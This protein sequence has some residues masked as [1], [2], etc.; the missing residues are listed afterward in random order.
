MPDE[1]AMRTISCLL[2]GVAAFTAVQSANAQTDQERAAA[3]D[4]ANA[5]HT[6]FAA[7][8]YEKAIDSLTRAEQLVH[9]PTHL[10]FLARAQTKLG[11]LVAAHETYLKITRET[12][13]SNAP[14]AFVAAQTSAEQEQDALEAR[15]PSV[16]VTLRGP[17]SGELNVQMD[18][19]KL[20]TAMIGIP[21][22]ADPGEHVF[23]A[24]SATSVSEAVTIKLSEA[25]KQSVALELRGTGAVRAQPKAAPVAA[26]AG[27]VAAS[28]G[29]VAASAATPPAEAAGT[30]G[31]VTTAPAAPAS[32]D[33]SS[34]GG[35]G[36][37]VASVISFGIG[38]V[39]LG[40]GTYYLLQAS[41]TRN[42][43]DALYQKCLDP[44]TS[45]CTDL[46]QEGPIHDKD[47]EATQQN[48]IGVVALIGGGVGVI[49]GI[50][51]LV[52]DAGH[53]S[54]AASSTPRLMPVIGLNSLGLTGTF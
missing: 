12:L 25:G 30:P 35:H 28:A 36:L 31:A 34:G 4:A 19:T 6:A 38:A 2:L 51:F 49:A 1:T 39:G 50:A 41:T 8:N 32:S 10:L 5:G 7:G 33:S 17:Q 48:K 18:G 47:S 44:K 9:A 15:L 16:T 43:S 24:S 53:D 45:K 46:T 20:P 13:A 27:P 11:R 22:P 29:P 26:S 14:K 23:K 3:R 21:I 42:E 52:A 54:K 40:L 37:R